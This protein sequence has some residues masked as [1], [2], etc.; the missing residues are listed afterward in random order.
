MIKSIRNRGILRHLLQ[1]VTISH[2]NISL[3]N[4]WEQFKLIFQGIEAKDTLNT[5]RTQDNYKKVNSHCSNLSTAK[6]GIPD[7]QFVASQTC[8]AREYNKTD[9]IEHGTGT[10]ARF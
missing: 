2:G 9:L 7:L 4:L 3:V 8:G 1:I 5:S 10:Y 6:V